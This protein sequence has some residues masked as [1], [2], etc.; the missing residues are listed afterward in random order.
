MSDDAQV[1]AIQAIY[2][3]NMVDVIEQWERHITAAGHDVAP[4]SEEELAQFRGQVSN[5]ANVR[6]FLEWWEA[7]E[8]DME[9]RLGEGEE[10]EG[11]N[12]SDNLK[13]VDS[14]NDDNDNDNKN[15][16]MADFIVSDAEDK[17]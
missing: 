14:D 3:C 11:D 8:G 13:I 10:G 5:P 6:E 15:E 7:E 12:D 9:E 1:G 4:V 17:E 2:Q 16:E